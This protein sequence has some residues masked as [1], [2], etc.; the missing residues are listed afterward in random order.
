[1]TTGRVCRPAAGSGGAEPRQPGVAQRGVLV[2]MLD[3]GGGAAVLELARDAARVRGCQAHGAQRGGGR[4]GA[5][6][7]PGEL[8]VEE[9]G[10][11]AGVVGHQGSTVERPDDVGGELAERRGSDDVPGTDAVDVRGSG[12]S[13]WIDQRRPF[14]LDRAVVGDGDQADLDDPVV[15]LREQTSGLEINDGVSGHATPE[16]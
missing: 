10:V 11:E 7:R 8:V 15:A 14:V 3:P 12:I 13:L 9:L 2:P 6:P 16:G 4:S 1:M 5:H